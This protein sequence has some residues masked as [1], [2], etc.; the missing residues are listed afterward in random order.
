MTTP[1]APAKKTRRW[2]IRGVKVL[3]ILI[4]LLIVLIYLLFVW[5]FWG[6]PFN[7]SRHGPVPLTPPWALECWLWEDDVNTEAS[8]KELLEGYAKFD[9][10]V[11]TIL[12]DSPWSSRYNDFKVDES[13]YPEPEKFFRGLQAQGYRV[14][15]WMTCMVNSQSKDTSIGE[16]QEFYDEARAKGFL[17][18]RGAQ[19]RWWKGKGGFI[20][21]SNPEAMKWWHG[22]Q[23]Q[24]LD[25]GVDGWKLDGC[26]TFFSGR[27][28][29]LPVPFNRS[30]SG[31]MTTRQY[32]DRY[33]REEYRF[34]LSQNPEFA[35]LVRAMDGKWSHPEG[36][37]PLDAATV[38]W[39]GDKC[40]T[41]N[42]RDRGLESAL[43]D[44]LRSARLGY[45]VIGSDVAGYHGRS[46]PDDTGPATG[47]LLSSWKSPAQSAGPSSTEFGTAQDTEI[48]PNI[49]IRWSQFSTFCGLFLNGGH[50]DR[51]LWKRTQP[52]LEIIRKFSWLHT[53]LVPYMYSQVVICHQGGPPL[54]RPLRDGDFH[55]MF[56]DDFLVAPIHKDS[57]TRTVSLPPGQWR[58]FFDDGEVINGPTQI[59]REFALDEFPV[60]VREGAIVPLKISRPYTG[61]GD[62][63]SAEFTTWL[64]YPNRKN[65]FTLWHPDAHPKLEQTKVE[66]ELD[67]EL[68]V[69]FSGKREPH[70]LRIATGKKPSMIRLDGTDLPE[71]IAW[72]WDE[73][74]RL[75]IIKTRNYAEGNYVISFR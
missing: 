22:L 37:S 19:Y 68:K 27:L 15:L 63:D 64:I 44:I 21:Y 2:L 69:R 73:Q 13:R 52:E 46:N 49:Y 60:F 53:E 71:G 25:W 57:L 23:Q 26:D 29:K 48:A 43:T 4:L 54:M 45:C 62:K 30:H 1:R 16:S 18:G 58:Y 47:A 32:M 5:P 20:D 51:R 34:G 3:A 31:W 14:V 28:G 11:R 10:P 36:F 38:T 72:N 35:I 6:I 70:I 42:H 67:A 40:H 75:L 24:V 59:T 8:V 7:Q 56:G 17:A 33:S 55:Y 61:L 50:G 41:W 39:V 74:R 65:Q 12:I 66:V 9:L